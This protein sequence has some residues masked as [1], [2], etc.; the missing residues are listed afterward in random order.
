MATMA[1]TCPAQNI[2][3]QTIRWSADRSFDI[4][5]GE[6]IEE[7]TTLTSYA[8]RLE[9][10]NADG[11]VRK[12]YAVV[13][14]VQGWDNIGLPGTARYRINADGYGGVAVFERTSA[15]IRITLT[16]AGDVPESFEILVNS[17]Q[18]L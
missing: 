7:A 5:Q 13:S 2:A 16:V 14:I 10:R 9:W 8:D 4:S 1:L 15:G 18:A 11:S 6:I 12:V 3:T 17:Y